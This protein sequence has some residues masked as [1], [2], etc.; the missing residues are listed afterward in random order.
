MF[1]VFN[2]IFNNISVTGKSGQ[3]ILYVEETEH[4]EKPTDMSD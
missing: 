3:Y 1:M 2:T 4:Q